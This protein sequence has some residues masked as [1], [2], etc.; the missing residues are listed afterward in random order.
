MAAENRWAVLREEVHEFF[1]LSGGLIGARI[2]SLL[3]QGR[4]GTVHQSLSSLPDERKPELFRIHRSRVS[5]DNLFIL[6]IDTA[7]RVHICY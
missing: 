2:F 7:L 4:L 5:V 6:L 1:L 3:Q